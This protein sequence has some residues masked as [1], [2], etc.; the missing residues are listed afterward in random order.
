[1]FAS[2]SFGAIRFLGKSYPGAQDTGRL[3]T[4]IYKEKKLALLRML[5]VKFIT[6][7]KATHLID[8]LLSHKITV[9]K[10]FAPEHGFRSRE[11][12]GA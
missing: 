11:D 3:F 9:I 4:P 12:N 2:S 5:L 7:G 1:M 6:M 8:S 10:I